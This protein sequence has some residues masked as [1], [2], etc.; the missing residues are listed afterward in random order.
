MASS[1]LHA[2]LN[3]RTERNENAV[4]NGRPNGGRIVWKGANYIGYI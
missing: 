2:S 1:E 3:E 4:N